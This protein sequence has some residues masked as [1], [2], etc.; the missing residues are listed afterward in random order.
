MKP[1]FEIIPLVNNEEKRRFELAYNGH[2]A[3]INYGVYGDK[4]ALVHTEAPKELQGTGA[5]QA[6]VEK[7]L[8]YIEEN[9]QTVLPYCPYVF[10][11]IK[12]NPEWKRVVNERFMGFDQL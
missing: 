10:G 8:M 7:T 1:E 11:F 12:K 3:F 6:L 2:T 9:N 5:A 4:I